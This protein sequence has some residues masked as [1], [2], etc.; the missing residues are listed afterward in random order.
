LWYGLV[1]AV[2]GMVGDLAMS[3]F[4]RD[5]GRKDSS[6]WLPGL[7]GVLDVLDSVLASAPAA[8]FCWVAGVVG[9]TAR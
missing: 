7:G 4:K 9:P 6:R 1:V 3:M 2:F 8:Y 5:V